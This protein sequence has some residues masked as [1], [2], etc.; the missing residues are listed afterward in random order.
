MTDWYQKVDTLRR[1]YGWGYLCEMTG[2]SQGSFHAYKRG[3]PPT[4]RV[5]QR[6]EH[7]LNSGKKHPSVGMDKKKYAQCSMCLKI[8]ERKEYVAF[9]SRCRTCKNKYHR[10][11]ARHQKATGDPKYRVRLDRE[12]ERRKN[13][14]SRERER[15]S[16]YKRRYGENWQD[17]QTRNDR[18]KALKE[19][20]YGFY[21][22]GI[23]K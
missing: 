11:W 13:P 5:M 15:M 8:G 19:A 23:N 9:G 21:D 14:I 20:N 6:I 2:T 4:P 17:R 16:K 7:F 1:H 22:W 3:K 10:E 12:N 18:R